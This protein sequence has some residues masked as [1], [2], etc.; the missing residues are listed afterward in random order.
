MKEKYDLV[1]LSDICEIKSGGTPSRNEKDNYDGSIPWA[2]ISDIEAS[3]GTLFTTEETITEKGLKAIRN[4]IFDEGTLLFAMYGS[5]GKMAFTEVKVSTNQA[6]LGINIKDQSKLYDRYLYYW[7]LGKK[8]EFLYLANGVTQKNL[9]ATFL[10]NVKIPLPSIELQRR[11]AEILDKADEIVRKRKGSID[12]T[13]QLQKSIFLDMFGDPVTNSK[14]WEIKKLG[15]VGILERGKSKHRPRNDPSLLG[16]EYPLIQTGDVANSKG[17]IKSY[18]QTYSEKGLAQSKLWKSGTLCITIAANIADTGI[19][20]FDACFPD[21][22]VGFSPSTEVTTEYIQGWFDFFQPILEANAPQSAQKNINL[23]IL[24]NLNV[25]IAPIKQQVH[26][27]QVINSLRKH[28]EKYE[29]HLQESEN[30]FN[31]LL[32]RAF[33]GEL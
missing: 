32:Q 29:K 9:S 30:L 12:L 8:N 18:T 17:L 14:G 23:N 5:V 31:A 25:M 7:L 13:E 11:I 4:R 21:S 2:K 16:G 27:S 3:N 19:L 20:L 33:K 10:R 22:I 15:D 28:L 26:Y 1:K 24:K 6:I